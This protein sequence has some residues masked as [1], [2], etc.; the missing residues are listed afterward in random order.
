MS[1]LSG[2][3]EIRTTQGKKINNGLGSSEKKKKKSEELAVSQAPE[4]WF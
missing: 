3:D 4:S 1:V 2:R